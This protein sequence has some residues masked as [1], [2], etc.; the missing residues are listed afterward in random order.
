MD[1]SHA[2]AHLNVGIALKLKNDLAGARA[3][4]EQAQAL[5]GEGPVGVEAQRLLAQLKP[6]GVSQ[7]APQ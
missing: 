5:G 4:L 1:R 6:R 3:A 2:G 7:T